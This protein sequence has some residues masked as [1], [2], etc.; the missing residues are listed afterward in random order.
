MASKIC[1]VS[2]YLNLAEKGL[3]FLGHSWRTLSRVNSHVLKPNYCCPI[4]MTAPQ[5][6]YSHYPTEYTYLALTVS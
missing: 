1:S 5:P 6:H 2:V 4:N 3:D